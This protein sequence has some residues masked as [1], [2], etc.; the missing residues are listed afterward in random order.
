MSNFSTLL[1]LAQELV[2]HL[3][4]KYGVIVK[5][6]MVP[7]VVVA[8][9]VQRRPTNVEKRQQRAEEKKTTPPVTFVHRTYQHKHMSRENLVTKIEQQKTEMR[10]LSSE[11]EKLKRQLHKQILQ[12]GVTFNNPIVENIELKDLMST[13]QNDFEQAF[14]NPNS[15]QRL[16]WE[17]QIKYNTAGKNGMRWHP[18]LIRWCL[19][20]RSKSVK[21]YDSMR[22]SCFIK[23]PSTRT[24]FDYSHYT[25]SALGFQP[26]VIKML[27]DEASK[28]AMYE[29]NHKSFVGILF[30]EIKIQE[31]LVFDKHTGELIG[32]CDLDSIGNEI[33]N[34]ENLVGNC[35]K[36]QL[37]KFMLVIMVR[38]VTN[39]PHLIKTARNCFSNSFSHKNTRRLWKNGKDISWMHIVRLFEEHCELQLYSP[40]P[41]LTRRHTDL[42]AFT[43]MKVNLAAQ[44][45]SGS[46]ANALEHL[47]DDS[48][49]ETV[50]FI[51]NFNKFFD[52]LNVRNLLE[53][54][55]KR[56]PDLE[57][58]TGVDDPRL[59]WLKSTF[60]DYLKEWKQ[61]IMQR[62]NL[63]LS[64]KLSMQ[65]SAQTLAGVK[66]SIN[67][68]TECVKFMLDQGADFV[69]TYN[70]NQDP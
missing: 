36:S 31:D 1:Q 5:V 62:P 59:N 45:L 9:L 25:K 13:Y 53:G 32:Y 65:L 35:K 38:G 67:S 63:T 28:L 37:A 8:R 33:L 52:C 23:L 42:A 2:M 68:I 55:N 29:D 30:D 26:D 50:L 24:L 60:L 54:C 70:F 49:S 18:M 34:L 43:Y 27:H 58:F 48:V 17:Q 57:P 41:K 14:P 56:N 16:F 15:L 61:S 6:I 4:M 20:M 44:I 21:A 64:Q 7:K 47:Y 12:N 22:D 46:V 40:C 11:V 19:F 66:I 39:V 51:R 10:T 69:L 3:R